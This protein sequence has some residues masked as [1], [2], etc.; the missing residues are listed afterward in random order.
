AETDL[1]TARSCT[2]PVFQF[3]AR[4]HG[5]S[6]AH[7]ASF[8]NP[9]SRHASSMLRRAGSGTLFAMLPMLFIGLVSQPILPSSASTQVRDLAPAAP[10]LPALFQRPP[11]SL[12]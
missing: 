2:Y 3:L 9:G 1:Q 5:H 7:S 11:P 10:S 12:S 6:S 4:S 8:V